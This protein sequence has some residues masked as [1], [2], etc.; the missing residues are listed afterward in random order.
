[1]HGPPIRVA[2]PNEGEFYLVYETE[3]GTIWAGSQEIAD[4][5]VYPLLHLYPNDARPST[6]MPGVI[7]KHL[8]SQADEEW[9]SLYPCGDELPSMR[10][11]LEHGKVRRLLLFADKIS[12]S[13]RT[14]FGKCPN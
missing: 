12:D 1:M 10:V 13:S 11:E 6:Y 2:K 8:R 3:Y 14:D 4:G 9:V 7:L 5:G